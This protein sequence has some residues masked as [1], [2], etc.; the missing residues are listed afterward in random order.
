V[1]LLLQILTLFLTVKL[2]VNI[3]SDDLTT[4]KEDIP[5]CLTKPLSKIKRSSMKFV[6]LNMAPVV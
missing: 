3:H 5:G 6:F 2:L 1:C 4:F